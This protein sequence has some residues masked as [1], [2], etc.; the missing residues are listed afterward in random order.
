MTRLIALTFVAVLVSGSAILAI[1]QHPRF[2]ARARLIPKTE[3][4]PSNY[5][6]MTLHNTSSR[7]LLPVASLRTWD[8][9]V[10]W[11]DIQKD[12]NTYD[13]SNLDELIELAQRRGADLVFTLGR[14]PR[15]ASASPDKKTPYGP[16]QCAPPSNMQY[17]DE[18]LRALLKH[19]D[20]KIKFWET[21]NE[22]QSPDSVVYC[23]DVPTMVELQRRAYEIIKTVDPAA[24]VLTPAPVGGYGP[25]WMS[26]FLA[27]GG[28]KY[29]D[30][31]AFHGYLASTAKPESILTTIADFKAAFAT[32]GQEQKPIWDTEAGWGKNLWL[33][34][35]DLQAAFLAKF[36]LLHWSAGVE[37]F[38]WYAYDNKVWGT[39]WDAQSGLHKPGVAYREVHRWLEGARMTSPCALNRALWT[40]HLIREHGY[41]AIV[42]WSSTEG[43]TD[44]FHLLD[45]DEYRQYRDLDGNSHIVIDRSIPLSNKPLLVETDAAF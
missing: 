25:A 44:T 24:M 34:D 2:S 26:R 11:A 6:G 33:S 9:A 40:C 37:R 29:A 14:T 17:W 20:G 4:I 30:I 21:W 7:L 1:S 31:M 27:G 23:G 16:G 32:Q 43:P 12:R 39:L 3:T 38:Y 13:W 5:F 41:R 19:A 10:S 45:S 36:Y 42:L 15:W 8:T 35:P 28:G 18:F 22:P